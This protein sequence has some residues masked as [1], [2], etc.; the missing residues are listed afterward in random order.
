[1]FLRFRTAR[2]SS[3]ILLP[4]SMALPGMF[5]QWSKTH[6]GKAWPEVCCRRAETKPKDSD[7][8]R[9]ALTWIRGV[10]SRGFSSNTQPRRRF[11]QLYTPLMASWGHVI[12]TR[13]TGSCSVGLPSI[14]AAKHA[15]RVGGMICP[16]P[17]WME[18]VC[19]V[20]SVRLKR[21]PRM[22]SSHRGPSLVA[23]WKALLTCSLISKR[24]WIACVTSTTT[25]A[26]SVSGP[27][28]QIL[29]AADSS[30]SYFSRKT[31]ARSFASALGPSFPSSMSLLIS[32]AIG[33]ASK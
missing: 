22:F 15:R 33:S 26:P 27:Q 1:M 19:R 23:H 12:S 25:L 7:T 8:G 2:T 13:K 16:A 28:H 31:F 21:M 32:S 14:S 11:M 4:T 5:S 30:Q 10:P 6:W 20:Q 18:S 9:Y 24:Y 17:R 29:R 3:F